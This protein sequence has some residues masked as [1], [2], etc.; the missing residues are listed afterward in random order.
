MSNLQQRQQKIQEKRKQTPWREFIFEICSRFPLSFN[1]EYWIISRYPKTDRIWWVET[2][3]QSSL[4]LIEDD[5]YSWDFNQSFAGLLQSSSFNPLLHRWNNENAEYADIVLNAKNVYLSNAVVWD[6]SDVLYSWSVKHKCNDVVASVMIRNG[7]SNV[8]QSCCVI[9]SYSVFYSHTIQDC[10]NIRFCENLVNCHECILSQ[11]LDSQSYC[12][13]NK[14]Y[15]ESEY[16]IK[17]EEVL[18]QRWDYQKLHSNIWSKPT[19][20]WSEQCLWSGIFNSHNVSQW[21]YVNN[22]NAWANL[23]LFWSDVDCSDI[24]DSITWWSP[25]WNHLYWGL[26]LSGEHIYCWGHCED[27]FN[28]YYSFDIE[29]CSYC[30]WCVWLQNKSYCVFNKQYTKE[31][32]HK[33]VDEI[34]TQM[35]ADWTLGNFFPWSA[36]PFYFN[37]TAAYLLDETFTKEEVEAAWYLRR[38]E[39]IAVDIPDWMEVVE[40]SELGEYEGWRD[41]DGKFYPTTQTPTPEGTPSP[42]QRTTSDGLSRYIDPDILKKVIKDE[43]WNVYRVIKMEYDFLM[44]YALPLPRKHWLQRLKGHFR[45]K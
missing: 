25:N 11:N 32:R 16:Q 22:V 42:W 24:Y 44:K 39:E 17:K 12:I 40:V 7:S 31:E 6:T 14:Q 15:S 18:S 38:D 10:S 36:N 34:F 8:F 43:E 13:D 1:R 2:T 30:V 29:S 41:S 45:V 37:D 3:T 9:N 33:K 28:V 4:E 27:C 19:N 21:Y 35:E 26:S 5:L 23:V 20:Q